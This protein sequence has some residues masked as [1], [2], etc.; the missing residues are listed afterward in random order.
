MSAVLADDEIMLTIKP[1]QHGSTYGMSLVLLSLSLMM[2]LSLLLCFRSS[3]SRSCSRCC[4]CCL[5]DDGGDRGGGGG[6]GGDDAFPCHTCN[7]SFRCMPPQ[8][9]VYFVRT[10]AGGKSN[11]CRFYG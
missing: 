8:P 6:G 1:G 9:R 5:C 2:L 3:F 7:Y 10:C 4:C 11:I